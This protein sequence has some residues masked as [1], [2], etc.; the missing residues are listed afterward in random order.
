M[1]DA[2]V[3]VDAGFALQQLQVAHLALGAQAQDALGA[4]QGDAGGIVTPV[5]QC[6]QARDQVL[7]DVAL[8][9]D[10]DD[11]AH[12]WSLPWGPG[13][14]FTG[15]RPGL[16]GAPAVPGAAGVRMFMRRTPPDGP[17]TSGLGI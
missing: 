14:E 10:A 17:D 1:G 9:A 6:A 2:A 7:D 5:L 4:E 12:V 16:R 13:R 11:A 15:R 8:G 3:A